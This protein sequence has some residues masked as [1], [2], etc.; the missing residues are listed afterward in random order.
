MATPHVQLVVDHGIAP[1]QSLKM[2][3]HRV[4]ARVSIRSLDKALTNGIPDSADVCVILPS[5]ACSASSLERLVTET[6]ARACATLVLD[7][8]GTSRDELI[9]AR[10]GTAFS[11][12]VSQPVTFT[13][14]VSL[15]IGPFRRLPL[16]ADELTGRIKALCE[17][18][19]PFRKMREEIAE[20][21][22]DRPGR[23]MIHTDLDE[24]IRLA[25][26]IQNDLLPEPIADTAPL[27]IS[28]LYL[29]ADF[30][31]G[32][33]YDISRLDEDRFGFSLADATGHGLP[34]ALL[35]ILV[36]NSLR[37]KEIVNGSYRII[38]PDELLSRLNQDL[39]AAHL[40]Q[41]HFITA[42]HA[43][44]DR[45]TGLIRWARGG[46]PYPILFRE[47]RTPRQIRSGG[48]LLGAF[49]DQGFEVVDHA[50]EAGDTLLF[51]TDGLEALLLRKNE[52]RGEDA[53]LATDWVERF[54]IYGPEVA[55]DEIRRMATAE[56]ACDWSRD[57][58]TAIAIRMTGA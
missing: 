18:R 2:A 16:N 54:R 47:D 46:T 23:S 51:Y 31:S 56:A 20:L 45:S 48:G 25:G 55:L 4:N 39:L 43:V 32:D 27:T 5:A 57:D 9:P 28:T 21:R 1:P 14:R 3:L 30:V 12:E 50:F 22:R 26:Q 37:G 24:Q 38:E 7:E 11:G 17:I 10:G 44:F 49:E 42:M 40:R 41:C 35:A 19:R 53:I 6:S 15:P 36:K 33:T 34:A 8:D 58:I 29:P 52:P 13:G